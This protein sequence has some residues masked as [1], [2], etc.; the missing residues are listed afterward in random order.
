MNEIAGSWEEYCKQN[1]LNA[2]SD[3]LCIARNNST[4][5]FFADRETVLGS[6][7]LDERKSRAYV[8]IGSNYLYVGITAT[9]KT[10]IEAHSENKTFDSVFWL[11]CPDAGFSAVDVS[12]IEKGVY[13]LLKRNQRS[14]GEGFNVCEDNDPEAFVMGNG[15][16]PN[17]AGAAPGGTHFMGD[18]WLLKAI[19]GIYL[20][21]KHEMNYAFDTFDREEI[22]S[23]MFPEITDFSKK[24]R[25]KRMFDPGRNVRGTVI[26]NRN[27][28]ITSILFIL[29]LIVITILG[30]SNA[31]PCKIDGCWC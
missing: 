25:R 4:A 29:A 7:K 3:E 31:C 30:A 1:R 16:T 22:E 23:A 14:L 26:A 6:E 11:E 17:Q 21:L 24:A 20:F 19:E 12:L 10:R 8:L 2:T 9:L 27:Y 5:F 13:S 15:V 28:L 18:V